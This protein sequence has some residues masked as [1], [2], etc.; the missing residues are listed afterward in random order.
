M[1]GSS[2]PGGKAHLRLRRNPVPRSLQGPGQEEI[3]SRRWAVRI[4]ISALIAPCV[5]RM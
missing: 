4:N 2:T 3:H 1:P 5:E